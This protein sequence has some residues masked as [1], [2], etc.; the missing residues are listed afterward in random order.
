[1]TNPDTPPTTESDAGI[2]TRSGRALGSPLDPEYP[3]LVRRSQSPRRKKT[4]R[5]AKEGKS[6]A[7]EIETAMSVVTKDYT[8]P[9]KDME[10]W[11]TRD[12]ETRVEEGKDKNHIARPMNS[13]MLYR[14]AYADRIKK[15][16]KEM[17][18]QIVSKVAGASWKIE[19]K[20][21]REVYERY[22]N[23]ERENHNNAHP[24]YKFAPNKNGKS[25][26]RKDFEETDDEGSEWGGP[27]H[28]SKRSRRNDRRHLSSTPFDTQ[29]APRHPLEHLRAQH[30][31]S[32]QASNPYGQ[33]P[34]SYAPDGYE[35]GYWQQST[36]P[37]GQHF[38]DV[39]YQVVQAPSRPLVG[40]PNGGYQDLLRPQS[41][42]TSTPMQGQPLDPRLLQFDPNVQYVPCESLDPRYAGQPVYD[43]GPAHAVPTAYGG[44]N[45]PSEAN[46]HPGLATLTNGS[47]D[48]FYPSEQP[49]SDFDDE[50]LKLGG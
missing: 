30:P 23:T 40:L 37:Y 42:T 39:Q 17:N 34:T 1:M 10:A 13:F 28:A 20:E 33:P 32:Y 3:E 49:G 8:I 48:W 18:H 44:Y 12:V 5:A 38:E 25:K 35:G 7:I 47:S 21:V 50:L 2:R 6:E 36:A 11:V 4:P 24:D 14:S 16:C 29:R 41:R 19:P 46:H 43:H 45:Y 26:K 22:A 9:L 15:Y 31:S 27:S